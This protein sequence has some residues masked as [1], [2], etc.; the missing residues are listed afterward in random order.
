MKHIIY[1]TFLLSIAFMGIGCNKFFDVRPS[2]SS[3][4]PTT[5][6][7]FAEMLNSDSLVTN[8]FLL[9]DLM[10]DDVSLAQTVIDISS[11][12]FKNTYYW[13]Q[14]IW[15][16]GD[17]DNGYNRSYSR[18]LQMNIVLS[19]I[20]AAKTS[21]STG[22]ED[23]DR[24]KSQALI[25]RASYYLQLVNC[26][27]N[28]Y[29]A[30][31][32]SFDLGVP[33]VLQPDATDYPSRAT[34]AAIY[35]QILSDLRAAAASN[36]LQDMGVDLVHPGKLAAFGLL[37]RTY[38]Y[39]AKYDS[40][41]LYADKVLS[42][43]DTLMP[44][45][46][47]AKP[48]QLLDLKKN[49]EILL[50]RLGVD[51]DFYKYY[52]TSIS[53]STGLTTALGTTDYRRSKMF[54]GTLYNLANVSNLVFDYSVKTSEMYLIKAECLAR[55][56]QN[57]QAVDLLNLLRRKRLSTYTA[58]DPNSS[59]VLKLV[60]DERRR[61]LFY[62]GGLRI[63]D[64]KRLNKDASFKTDLTRLDSKSNV[65]AT[66]PAGSPRYLMQFSPL[67]TDNNPNIV[68]NQR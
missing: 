58:L 18:I 20:D 11:N 17:A 60:M 7:D 57:T 27:G 40:A 44:Y 54:T 64:L 19:R 16:S 46:S 49:P 39:M 51:L 9:M 5:V 2:S 55:N 65:L 4:N 8:D 56:N 59:N 23:K 36:N 31:T 22:A 25:N 47:F 45:A 6:A 14:S 13:N 30:T 29:D 48:T 66:L 12:Y 62:M 34:V 53:I 35:D 61:E 24:I 63:F 3:I 32:S 10:S 42:I 21:D 68:P 43:K 38:L 50:T 33:L 52:T 1:G 37:A 15:N 41:Q 67:I 26:Y 28:A